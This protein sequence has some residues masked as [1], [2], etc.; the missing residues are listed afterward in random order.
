MRNLI[1]ALSLAVLTAALALTVDG[2]TAAANWTPLTA[3][4]H[5][6][7]D[8]HDGARRFE[9]E[10][11][12]AEDVPGLTLTAV[13]SALT[14]T[15]GRLID[16]K[17]TIRGRNDSVTVQVRPSGLGDVTVSLPATTDCAAANA[18]CAADGR[19]L[20]ALSAAVPGSLVLSVAD[21]Q[22]D[23][24]SR[25]IEFTVSLSAASRSDVTV[26]IV[27]S[28]GTAT[29][30]TPG[31]SATYAGKDF[32][33]TNYF[34][35][36]PWRETIT[37]GQTEI[38]FSVRLIDNAETEADKT[39]TLTL[40]NPTGAS[41][42][43]AT[44]TG[45]I[46]DDETQRAILRALTAT[47]TATRVGQTTATLTIAGHTGNW[48]YKGNAHQC[49][50]VP[51]GTTAVRI[52]G[53]VEGSEYV[54]DAYS[55]STCTNLVAVG[56]NFW[57]SLFF[58]LSLYAMG[59]ATGARFQ[60][61]GHSGHSGDWWYKGDQGGS[62]CTKADIRTPFGTVGHVSGL[63]AETTYT[64]RVYAGAGCN[65]A[66]ELGSKTFT[67][68]AA[69]VSAS[70]HGLPDAHDGAKRFSFE[71]RFSEEVL[72]P[73]LTTVRDAL[74]VTGGRLIDVKRTVRGQDG[75]F[76][77]QVRPAGAGDVTIVLAT[78]AGC[79]AADA[80]CTTG[81]KNLWG[82]SATVPGPAVNAPAT[83]APTISGTAQV[84]GTLTASTAGI[85]DADGL[86]NAS[87]TYQWVSVR[88]GADTDIAG[89]TGA[90]YTL[91]AADAGAAFKVRVSFT[92]DA[93]FNETLL[94]SA[95]APGALAPLT[96]AFLRMPA[97]HDGAKRFAFEIR[98][99]EEVAG[100]RLTAVR[101]ALQV[102]N[103][104]FVAVKRAAAGQSRS[105][106]VQ[107]RPNG[108]EDVTVSL[109]AMADCSAAGAICTQDG[110][111]LVS[112][113]TAT[114]RG[115]VALSVADAR[116]SEA[117]E[118]IAFTVSLSRAASGTVTVDYATRDGT[119]K[120]GKDYTF[121]RGTL[122]FAVGELE[123]TVSVP[124]LDDAID[125][126]AETF[127]LKLMNARGAA[128]GDGEA[129]GTILNSDPL[130]T[131][132][133]SR[134]G[135]TV[136]DHVT[137]AVSDRLA[138]PLSGAQVTVGGQSVDLA[139]AQDHAALT[140]AL[141][142]IARVL[143]GSVG[144]APEDDGWPG[145]GLGLSESPDQGSA[146]GRI[147]SGREVLLGSAFHLATDGERSG[148]GL[149]AWGRVT[150]G[151]F[152]GEAP[153]DGGNVTIDGSVTTGIL[154]A[155]ATWKRLLAGVAVSLSEGEG[156]FDQPGVDSGTI[157]STMTT[158]SPYAR[159]LV[160]DRLSVWGLAGFGTGDMTIVQAANDRQPERISRSDIEM[161]LA[162]LGGRGALMEA[163]ETSGLDLAM[164]ADAFFVETESD[165]VSNEGATTATA[166]RVRLALDGSRAFAMAGGGTL[167]PG[168]ELAL[169]HDGGDA[170]TGAGIELGGRVAYADPETGLSVEGSVRA[171]VAHE[172]S[173]YR[174]WGASGAV[175]LTPGDKGHGLSFRLAP[176]WGAASSGVDRLW[177]ARDAQGLAP[178]TS[179]EAT[180]RLEGELGYGLGLVGDRFTGT[181]T[182][183]FG[184]SDGGREVRIGWRLISVVPNDPGFEVSLDATRREAAN[185]NAPP[186]H[187]VMLRG[188]IRW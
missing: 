11:R 175:R 44:A 186:A 116:A 85:T 103:G 127:R 155:D 172:D 41:L 62:V 148:P 139:E 24:D 71:I 137:A 144:P 74:S 51:A 9:F 29:G 125:E 88:D 32:Y 174:E 8:A 33:H 81:G 146:S 98:F 141:D 59:D 101:A 78:S 95:T 128:I 118:A 119:A 58:M 43:D 55:E 3:S 64:Y 54:F 86:T 183:G 66:D 34:S 91:A 47:L 185:G 15:G 48:W 5:G 36:A 21:A 140:Q 20:A 87:F 75:S 76:T 92:D 114:V 138:N 12:F 17:R 65:A 94:S 70:F 67:T 166:N 53:L 163:D 150:V 105:I 157:E 111:K 96:A 16:V 102:T 188:S 82:R 171:L 35:G 27:T 77:A 61:Y 176:V 181:P 159:F 68:P 182:L 39:F 23:E 104:K 84:G 184:L 143:G 90:S 122:S 100:L 178:G 49:T 133:L 14:V 19:K 97:E 73:K 156:S 63:V 26:E 72:G 152:D 7:P 149:A 79:P 42:G 120:A 161:R 167:T 136:A 164:K 117:D 52:T 110:R 109:S 18:I 151:S 180:Q 28:N 134:F 131:M 162:A 147:P 187:G 83:G 179:F 145:T 132:W 10:L 2:R 31:K 158:V 126:G 30:A 142:G 168:L 106:T 22:A 160:N 177:S 6:L 169:R 108:A 129:T 115:P 69:P 37:A 89:A 60:F 56:E 4:F 99:S 121:T 107:V 45:T 40:K 112:A 38:E 46:R 93:G 130:Q 154:G 153:A 13:E 173:G 50:A 123:K 170:E 57:T 25:G 165:P 135:R 113:L 124:L 80:I 1:A